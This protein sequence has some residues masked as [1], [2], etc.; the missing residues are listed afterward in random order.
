MFSYE[1]NTSKLALYYLCRY[2]RIQ[3]HKLI[4]CQITNPHLTSLGAKEIKR[5]DFL[6]ILYQK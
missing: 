3:K 2:M 6:E 4:D 5:E 1:S